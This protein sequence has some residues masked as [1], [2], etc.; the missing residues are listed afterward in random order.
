MGKARAR[1]RARLDPAAKPPEHRRKR[2]RRTIPVSP[3]KRLRVPLPKDAVQDVGPVKE[4][5]RA[6]FLVQQ[7]KHQDAVT[8][9]AGLIV[10]KLRVEI[11]ELVLLKSDETCRL[12]TDKRRGALTSEQF[13]EIRCRHR[14]TSCDDEIIT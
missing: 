5:E 3:E 7:A 13:L 12:Q 6:A 4:H 1:D 9:E 2:I 8:G 14:L 11:V 10:G